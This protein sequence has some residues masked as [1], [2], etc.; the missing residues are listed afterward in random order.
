MDCIKKNNYNKLIINELR[1]SSVKE[2]DEELCF[3]CGGFL[4]AIRVAKEMSK[5]IKNNLKIKRC[6]GN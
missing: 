4:L 5:N 3:D 1:K 6:C 2:T